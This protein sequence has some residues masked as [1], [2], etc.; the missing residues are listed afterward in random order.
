MKPS[1]YKPI[2]G[3][4]DLRNWVIPAKDFMKLWNVQ[5]FL[6]KCEENRRA[7]KYKNDPILLEGVKLL[8]EQYQEVLFSYPNVG[9]FE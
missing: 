3:F 7:G 9:G 4:Y 8:S 1:D 5:K 2:K 6:F